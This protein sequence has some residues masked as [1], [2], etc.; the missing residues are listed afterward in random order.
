[1]CAFE[2][3]KCGELLAPSQHVELIGIGI[4]LGLVLSVTL[5]R[6]LLSRLFEV[7]AAR[8]PRPRRNA[9]GG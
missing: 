7:R 2:D 3:L 4:L 1:M 6:F 5:N 9:R 8:Y